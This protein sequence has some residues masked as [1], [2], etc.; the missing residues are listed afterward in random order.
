[1]TLE[2]LRL[3]RNPGDADERQYDITMIQGVDLSSRKDA[4][5]IAPPGQSASNNILLGISGMEADIEIRFVIHDDGTDK[6]NGTHTSDVITVE[7]QIT[8]LEGTMH[9]PGFETTWELTHTT[10]GLFNSDDVYVENVDPTLL[11]VDSPKWKQCRITLRRG[12]SA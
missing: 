2:T 11:N 4:V 1:M 7:D 5:S 9:D 3:T 12:G 10:G 6:A 8:Y